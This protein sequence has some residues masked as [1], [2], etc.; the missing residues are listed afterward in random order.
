MLSAEL[1]AWIDEWRLGHIATLGA[2]GPSVSP[3]G[4]FQALD[5]ERIAFAEI[6]SPQ[7]R[8]HIAQDPRVEVTMVDV[9]AR[10]GARLRG[11]AAFHGPDSEVAAELTP[12]WS[13]VFG[14]DLAARFRGFVVIRLSEVGLLASP[15]YDIGA[16]EAE[17]RRSYLARFTEMQR[18][19]L[20]A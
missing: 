17:M 2:K 10:R 11:T 5:A 15:A 18:S 8:A 7:T 13:A 9:F 1:I 4:T 12:R 3:K 6:R 20:D 19:V 16:T 14:A